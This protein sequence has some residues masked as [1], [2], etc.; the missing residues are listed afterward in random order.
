MN[1]PLQPKYFA[2]PSLFR[3]WLEKNNSKAKEIIVGFYKVTSGKP[4]MTWSESVDQ[5]LCFGWIDSVR[6]S[7]DNDSYCNRFTPRKPGSNWSTI[8]IA[9]VKHL[10]KQ[11]MMQPTG[12]AAFK[13]RKAD[14]SGIYSHENEVVH[15]SP[16]FEKQFKVNKS[17]WKYFHSLAP[18][19][20]KLS[21]NWVMGAKQETTRIKRLNELISDSQQG[22]NRWKENKNNGKNKVTSSK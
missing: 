2:T 7:I 13:L 11:G 10:T 22:T 16:G 18:G 14:K 4:S 9:K 1:P 17:A 12:L 15:L 5:A 6:K 19:Y 3:K 21:T 20:R 8:N